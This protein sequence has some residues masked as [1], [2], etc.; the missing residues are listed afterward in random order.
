MV[1]SVDLHD[2][3]GKENKQTLANLSPAEEATSKHE[4]EIEKFLQEQKSKN[5]QD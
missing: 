1:E 5:T 4:V 3:A 2:E